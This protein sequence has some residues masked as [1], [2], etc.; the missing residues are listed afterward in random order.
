MTGQRVEYSDYLAIETGVPGRAQEFSFTNGTLQSAGDTSGLDFTVQT[1]VGVPPG[2]E[3]EEQLRDYLRETLE[4]VTAL[5]LEIA[6]DI[7]VGSAG[8]GEA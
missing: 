1:F 5:N 3:T 2:V 4:K 8:D 6:F 7:Q